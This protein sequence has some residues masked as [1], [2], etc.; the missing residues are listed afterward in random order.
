MLLVLNAAAATKVRQA[1]KSMGW[2]W[3]SD[4]TSLHCSSS[5]SQAETE[6]EVPA[7][8]TVLLADAKRHKSVAR[9]MAGG[10]PEDTSAVCWRSETTNA[11]QSS[12]GGC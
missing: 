2:L 12:A 9:S 6:A 3:A 11:T 10:S 7:K 1:N 5:S 4:T 8:A